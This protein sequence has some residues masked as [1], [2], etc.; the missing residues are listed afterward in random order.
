[1]GTVDI[2]YESAD[3]KKRAVEHTRSQHP[4][5]LG[6]NI[7]F[8]NRNTRMVEEIMKPMWALK[9]KMAEVWTGDKND[10]NMFT[11]KQKLM[12]NKFVVAEIK[13]KQMIQHIQAGDITKRIV[14]QRLTQHD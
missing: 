2:T 12:V 4:K 3:A 9:K 13:D 11:S 10:V 14:F 7:Y 6:Q 8:Q 1:M 5:V